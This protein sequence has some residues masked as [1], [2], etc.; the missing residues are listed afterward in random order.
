LKS[1]DDLDAVHI[2]TIADLR[3][4]LAEE[5]RQSKNNLEYIVEMETT[6]TNSIDQ[7]KSMSVKAERLE[8]ELRRKEQS[9]IDLQERISSIDTTHET[10]LLLEEL[11][12]K[13]SKLEDL[14]Q[15]LDRV[16]SECEI[17]AA[18]RDGLRKTVDEQAD[19]LS[20]LQSTSHESVSDL[21]IDSKA[22]IAAPELFAA[23]DNNDGDDDSS[24]K[25]P[26]SPT[27]PTAMLHSQDATAE[28]LDATPEILNLQMKHAATLAELAAVTHRYKEALEKINLLSNQVEVVDD[29]EPSKRTP[30]NSQISPPELARSPSATSISSAVSA[31]SETSNQSD[32]RRQSTGSRLTVGPARSDFRS[33]RGDRTRGG[34]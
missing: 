19:Q 32:I 12:N 6:T 4:E 9:H 13:A 5:K 20:S 1:C 11:D 29:A 33:R 17:I 25:V 14:E 3:A 8:T 18:E 23:Q 28:T 2:K 22:L 15:R 26:G 27:T 16:V 10:Q 34:R 24:A 21:T 31:S 7:A 30:T